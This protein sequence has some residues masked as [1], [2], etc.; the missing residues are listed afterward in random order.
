MKK[1]KSCS[2]VFEPNDPKVII[3]WIDQD[4]NVQ[5]FCP[6]CEAVEQMEEVECQE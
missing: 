6:E 4:N 2:E 3:T 1:C 5:D